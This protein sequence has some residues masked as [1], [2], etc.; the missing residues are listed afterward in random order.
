MDPIWEGPYK[1]GIVGGKSN[2]TLVTMKRQKNQKAVER[3]QYEEVPCVTSHYIKARRLKQLYGH[4]L[5]RRG[6]SSNYAVSTLQLSFL[7][8]HSF[9]MKNSEV[10]ITWLGCMLTTIDHSCISKEDR[11][12]LRDSSQEL[13]P[14]RVQPFSS[15]R[16]GKLIVLQCERVNQFLDTHMGQLSKMG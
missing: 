5:T 15:V 10:I 3:L 1:I 13:H 7:L 9:S 14:L 11:G 6:L 2:Y 12:L 4:H 16:E 8:F